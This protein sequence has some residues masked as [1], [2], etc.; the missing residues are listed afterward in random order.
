MLLRRHKKHYQEQTVKA[1][2]EQ[3]KE[4]VQ[5]PEKKTVKK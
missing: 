3:K 4:P 5:K 1:N 2:V